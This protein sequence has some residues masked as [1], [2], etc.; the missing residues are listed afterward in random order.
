MRNV[1]PI[2][3]PRVVEEGVQPELQFALSKVIA[4]GRFIKGGE[5]AVF[6]RE[7]CSELQTHSVITTGNGTDALL[8]CL[9]ALDLREGDEVFAGIEAR[10]CGCQLAD[11]Q[12]GSWLAKRRGFFQ[13]QSNIAYSFV[14]IAGLNG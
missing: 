12:Y 5:V 10:S 6:E 7:L 9:M 14:R 2:F 3:R 13:D 8:A 1:V 11:I 4:E